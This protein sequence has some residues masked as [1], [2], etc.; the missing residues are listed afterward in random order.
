MGGIITLQSGRAFGINSTVDPTA[1][2]GTARADLIG[3]IHLSGDRSRGQEI[4]RYF[5]TTAVTQ[6][7]PGTYGTL[8]R[9]RLR[10][11]RLV[12]TDLSVAREF[13]LRFREA[14]LLQFRTEFFNL[15]NRPQLSNPNTVLG[16]AAFG[17]ILAVDSAPRILQFS[18]K[19]EF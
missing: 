7:L 12:N 17:Q 18:L 11:P 9:N 1:G 8:G 4:A 6:A 19:I 2:A 5:N 10:G 14:A 16:G 13:P 3:D 15:F